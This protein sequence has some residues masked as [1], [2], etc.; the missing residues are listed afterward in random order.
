MWKSFYEKD[1]L[2]YLKNDKNRLIYEVNKDNLEQILITK[3]NIEEIDKKINRIKNI[4]KKLTIFWIL[5]SPLL[6]LLFSSIFAIPIPFTEAIILKIILCLGATK[7]I[8]LGIN[9]LAH[10]IKLYKKTKNTNCKCFN[11]GKLKKNFPCI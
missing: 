9:S 3:N 1:N 10:F 8:V 7:F 4:D 5:K 2:A 6:A 11:R